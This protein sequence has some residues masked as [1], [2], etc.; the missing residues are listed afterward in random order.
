MNVKLMK[1]ELANYS[2]YPEDPVV[3]TDRVTFLKNSAKGAK[4]R[5]KT[6]WEVWFRGTKY[7]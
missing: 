2:Q 5:V 4:G 3:E 1:M 6:L 7:F